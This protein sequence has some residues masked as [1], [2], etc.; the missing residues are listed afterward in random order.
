MSKL[1]D[2]PGQPMRGW[3]IGGGTTP[4]MWPRELARPIRV[5]ALFS[6]VPMLK[7]AAYPSNIAD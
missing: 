5:D 2:N 4:K 7:G 3:T 6:E 1:K